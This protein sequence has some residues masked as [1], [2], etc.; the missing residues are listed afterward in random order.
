M[1]KILTEISQGELLDKIT[2]LE[3]KLKEIKNQAL[4]QEVEKEYEILSNIRNKNINNSEIID[5]LFNKLKLVNKEIWDIENIK[6]NYEKQNIFDEKFIKI[7]RDE[8]KAND[9]RA[10]IK[11]QINN[12]LESN[13]K[14]VKQHKL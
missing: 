2:I 14:E 1:G 7:S 8:Y 13:I 12:I 10:S 9:E 11:S 5:D 6:R 3:I 4:L